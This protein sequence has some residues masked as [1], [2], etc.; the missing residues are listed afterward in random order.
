MQSRYRLFVAKLN[1]SGS[2]LVFATYFGSTNFDSVNALALDGKGDI[3]LAGGTQSADFPRTAGS[4]GGNGALG[5]CVSKLRGDGAALLF[6]A[7]LG[8][9]S[10]DSATGLALDADGDAYVAGVT[11]SAQFP[12]TTGAF[13]RTLHATLAGFVC[14]LNASGTALLYSTLLGGSQVTQ[15]A[16]RIALDANGGITLS[17]LT[18][19]SD[20]P[21]TPGAFQET[22]GGVQDAFVT[23]LDPTLSTL[24][25][26]TFLGGSGVESSAGLVEDSTGNLWVTG[27]SN[28]TDFP[29]TTDPLSRAFA[30]SPCISRAATPFGNPPFVTPCLHAYLAGLS[31]DGTNLLY[32]APLGGSNREQ[33]SDLS[34]DV[35]GTVT[36]VGSTRSSDFPVTL[37]GFQDRRIRADC[38]YIASPSAI[39]TQPCDDA[40]LTKFSTVSP[41]PP[42]FE[43]RNRAGHLATPVAPNEIVA[44]LGTSIG[45]PAPAGLIIDPPGF[46][47]KWNRGVRV[48]FDGTAAPLIYLDSNEIDAIVPGDV[49]GKSR[50]TVSIERNESVIA[51]AAALVEDA[52]PGILSQSP[53]FMGQA[54]M[55]NQ[56]GTINSPQNP[57][58]AGSTVELYVLGVQTTPGADGQIA[59]AAIP[60]ADQPLV[61]VGNTLATVVYAGASPGLVSAAT[62][63]DFVVP[64]NMTGDAVPIYIASQGFASPFGIVVSIQ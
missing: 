42:A 21:V 41:A 53:G 36:V 17:G 34:L 28:S 20:F 9:G 25:F 3:F 39:D 43:I 58:K 35:S 47:S 29:I 22:F 63:I 56:D 54:A 57:A 16:G 2:A 6:S 15:P 7:V 24:V 14:K 38:L 5:A 49:A 62:Q 48:L 52:A 61:V 51:T 32:A 46:V 60:L 40:F 37:D 10:S 8:A 13:E 59:A 1:A 44:M 11:S 30:G 27:V 19:A 18:L 23:R 33:V 12:T 64:D 26:S 55:L 31:A 4:A 50:T 45:P